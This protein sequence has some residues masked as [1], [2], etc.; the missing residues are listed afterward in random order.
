MPKTQTPRSSAS[1]SAFAWPSEW[2]TP[3]QGN[4]RWLQDLQQASS[5]MQGEFN[6]ISQQQMDDLLATCSEITAALSEAARDPQAMASAP[7]VIS[8]QLMTKA[9]AGSQRW[10]EFAQRINALCLQSLN[11]P[12]A[13]RAEA[14]PATAGGSAPVAGGTD[15]PAG[16]GES[17]QQAGAGS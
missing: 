1:Q 10:L 15:R 6:R 7:W 8:G 3:L 9:G 12:L 16:A 4:G 13:A 5:E 2:A 14:G 17:S 11:G